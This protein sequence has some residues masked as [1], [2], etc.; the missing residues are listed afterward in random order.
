MTLHCILHNYHE[1]WE[2]FE[3]EGG[4]NTFQYLIL[5]ED[6]LDALTDLVDLV[7]SYDSAMGSL[8]KG[9]Q[10]L[11]LTVG[12][13][14]DDAINAV[15][16]WSRRRRGIRNIPERVIQCVAEIRTQRIY[17]SAGDVPSE[18]LAEI[19]RI[20]NENGRDISNPSTLMHIS[21]DCQLFCDMC[22]VLYKHTEQSVKPDLRPFGLLKCVDDP[23][24]NGFI[25]YTDL[26]RSKLIRLNERF[27]HTI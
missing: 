12:E 11:E 6:E 24:Y 13:S 10:S 23:E 19:G 8:D 26:I 14:R 5:G 2:D 25:G 1:C 7:K 18:G 22:K 21:T 4:P 27:G 17:V 16:D 15:K 20:L 3:T 9:Y